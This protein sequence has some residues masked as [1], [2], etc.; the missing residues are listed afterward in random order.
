M[1]RM[2]GWDGKSLAWAI[3][4]APLCGAN[5]VCISYDHHTWALWVTLTIPAAISMKKSEN[6]FM[7]DEQIYFFPYRLSR[8][9]QPTG[10]EKVFCNL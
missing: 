8:V 5:N 4:R 6:N 3:Y 7:N 2:V 9:Y 1:G 10:K